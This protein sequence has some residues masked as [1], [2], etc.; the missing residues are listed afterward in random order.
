MTDKEDDPI[1]AEVRRVREEIFARCDY[2][3]TKY[4]EFLKN[5]QAGSGRVYIKPP[6]RIPP[7][8]VKKVG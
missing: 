4:G 2:D 5:Q 1:V 6:E 3:L 8:D 7:T